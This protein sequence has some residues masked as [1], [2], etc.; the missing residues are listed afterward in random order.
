MVVKVL[1]AC[2]YPD[3]PR[4]PGTPRFGWHSV[5]TRDPRWRDIKAAVL[6]LDRDEWPFF[7]LHTEEP[8]E[9]D[10]PNNMLSIM[11]GR[12]EYDFL[13]SRD[14]GYDRY[15]DNSRGDEVIQ[16]WESD[17]GSYMPSRNLCNDLALVLEIARRFAEK[18]ELHPGVAWEEG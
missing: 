1:E 15:L 17:Q 8:P 4:E 18:G 16:I 13:L 11:G 9:Y 14:R 6:R 12:G 7:F 3:P 2:H 5:R 10:Q